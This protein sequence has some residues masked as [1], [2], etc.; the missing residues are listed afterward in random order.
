MFVTMK[1][2]GRGRLNFL[3]GGC[4]V[5]FALAARADVKLAGIFND[6]MVLQQNVP[7]AVWGWAMPGEIVKVEIG[8][9]TAY[10]KTEINNCWRV[11]IPPLKAS[12]KPVKFIV[13]GKNTI[14][15]DDVVV[16]EVWLASGQ[17]NMQ[18][19]LK[20]AANSSDAL[21]HAQEPEIRLCMVGNSAELMALQDRGMK[22]VRCDSGSAKSFSAVA[23]F[24]GKD[25]HNDLKVPIGLV[26]AYVAGT[27][28]QSWTDEESLKAD[29]KLKHY[30][31]ALNAARSAAST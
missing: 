1:S 23:Y 16:G 12:A 10:A 3:L 27:A 24:F 18:F 2:L 21:A 28:A 5:F 22:W 17:S 11:Q 15:L 13:S 8:D 19:S 31:D 29:P 4:V 20:N 9:D 26:G 25:L 7:L 14:S 6:H 30:L